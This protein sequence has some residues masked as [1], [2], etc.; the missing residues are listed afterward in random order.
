MDYIV[1]IVAVAV[2]IACVGTGVLGRVKTRGSIASSLYLGAMA[3]IM[4]ATL[5]SPVNP[6]YSRS[7]SELSDGL[8]KLFVS[9]LLVADV[10]L[11]SVAFVFPVERKMRFGEVNLSTIL[12]AVWAAVA[13][14]LGA[15][16]T[17]EF[18]GADAFILSAGM[19][20]V[21]IVNATFMVVVST[22]VALRALPQA[23]PEGRQGG[24]I[25]LAGLWILYIS[26]TPFMIDFNTG[27]QFGPE[28]SPVRA[29]LYAAGV[30]AVA[31]L[32]GYAIVS[33]RLVMSGPV[34][35]KLVSSSKAK[36]K[37]LI[38]HA[39]LVE[40]SKPDF[41]FKMFTDVLKGRC[42]E[43]END[44][45]FACE[46]L[47]CASCGLPCPCH[48]CGKYK[49]RP[50]GLIVTRQ[51][52]NDIRKKY[53]IQTTPIVW[54]STV[55]GQQNMDP[56]KLALLTDYITNFMETSPNGVVLVDGIEYLVTSNDF[57]RVQKA[58]DRWTECAMTSKSRLIMSIDDNAFD[59]KEVATMER[60]RETVRPNAKESW[61]IIPERI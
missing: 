39:Y 29:I 17:V 11:C 59:I 46:S 14:F 10:L 28:V 42:N 47:D 19:T 25:Y 35:E 53:Y 7:S 31:A 40:E 21:I 61:R 6:Y 9:G 36:F 24:T 23:T 3:T 57:Q 22:I 37:L 18:T 49:S 13:A 30:G 51:F 60:D 48:K 41:A 56:A 20:R 43:C 4:L 8:A 1:W 54:L 34:P 38:R 16:A 26:G 2:G 33:G 32:V 55:Q 52:T 50:Q 58:I 27:I 15:Q 44:D 12:L 5:A 45:S